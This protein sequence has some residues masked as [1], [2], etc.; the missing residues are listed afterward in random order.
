MCLNRRALLS[1]AY[2]KD[3]L[4]L[5]N[6]DFDEDMIRFYLI[7]RNPYLTYISKC[8]ALLLLALVF[9]E[10]PCTEPLCIP[11]W[12]SVILEMICLSI[13]TFRLVHELYAMKRTSFWSDWKHICQGLLITLTLI[14]ITQYTLLLEGTHK[15]YALRWSRPWRP[16]FFLNLPESRLLR[17]CCRNIRKI[18]PNLSYV[19][20]LFVSSLALS[21]LMAFKL[22]GTKSLTSNHKSKEYFNTFF[23][24]MWELFVLVTTANHPDIVLPAYK[25]SKWYALFFVVFI[26][27]HLY[28]F[29]SIV[30]AVVY[31]SFKSNLRAEVASN[32]ERRKSQLQ[33]AYKYSLK[34][35]NNEMDKQDF[36]GLLQQLNHDW[37]SEYVGALWTVLSNLSRDSEQKSSISQEEFSAI[38]QVVNLPYV[39]VSKSYVIWSKLF[40]EIYNSWL[41]NLI[42][43][44][45]KHEI[46]RILFDIIIIINAIFIAFDIVG[47]EL[48]FLIAFALE[49]CLKMYSWGPQSFFRRKWNMFDFLVVISAIATSVYHF[50]LAT[51]DEVQPL[52][53]FILV[54]R[55]LRL[56]K[57][58]HGM[59]R[60]RTVLNTLI[61]ILPSLA[62]YGGILM[63]MF[64]F[65]S[66]VGMAAFA[67]KYSNEKSLQNDD[68]WRT[69][70]NEYLRDSL[71]SKFDYCILNF[72]D[73]P[74]ALLFLFD[75]M[76]VNQWHI[77]VD[78]IAKVTSTWAYL[79]FIS[80]HF[81]CVTV[82][83]N[84]FIAFVIETFILEFECGA[85]NGGMKHVHQRIV[86]LGL[87]YSKN[88]ENFDTYQNFGNSTKQGENCNIRF[89]VSRRSVSTQ[90]IL[91]EL[92]Q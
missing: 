33:L 90:T 2:L 28:I 57:V 51:G 65:F 24:S 76:I 47:G 8:S 40:P 55:V 32:Q 62:T 23:E 52:I 37:S 78:G 4:T 6:N 43:D 13:L 34:A 36:F 84:I 46:F 1:Q 27:V 15:G 17:Q 58:F 9:V 12:N 19:I 49:I 26:I 18:I 64:Y 69:C 77:L 39:D 31:N 5:T 80:F 44:G 54:L 66:V 56:F 82:L 72:D 83:L 71:F 91:E 10:D 75:I 14:D 30:L 67:N 22:F 20:I 38:Y 68:V 63:M 11:F 21:A 59:T 70:N 50:I 16:F 87:S 7:F 81:C 89:L 45:T 88:Y 73:F 85:S 29:L 92:V 53:E 60:F 35:G 25:H 79:Y 61:R 41:S 86:D 48:V 74:S 42:R 3:A